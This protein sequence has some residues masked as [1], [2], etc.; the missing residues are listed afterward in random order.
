MLNFQDMDERQ[1][2][3]EFLLQMAHNNAQVTSS[4]QQ[5]KWPYLNIQDGSKMNKATPTKMIRSG[6]LRPK[7]EFV[8]PC[9]GRKPG[10]VTALWKTKQIH[11][12]L[13]HQ[14]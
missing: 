8:F 11:G 9:Y 4:S 6:N 14:N 5:N 7:S 2:E 3:H 12:I 1:P 13:S 10:Q